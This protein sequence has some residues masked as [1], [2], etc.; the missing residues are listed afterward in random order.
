MRSDDSI[1][2][3]PRNRRK[4]PSNFLANSFLMTPPSHATSIFFR[5]SGSHTVS[6]WAVDTALR[7][8]R[9]VGTCDPERRCHRVEDGVKNRWIR[10][11]RRYVFCS[12]F[13]CSF[14]D[15]TTFCTSHIPN[16]RRNDHADSSVRKPAPSRPAPSSISYRPNQPLY[17]RRLT[18]QFRRSNYRTDVMKPESGIRKRILYVVRETFLA[19]GALLHISSGVTKRQLAFIA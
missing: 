19:L 15:L 14:I 17:V 12:F 9:W 11:S 7:W 5:T 2:S 1:R 4:V 10:D 18:C 8:I 6:S 13:S 16:H 3:H